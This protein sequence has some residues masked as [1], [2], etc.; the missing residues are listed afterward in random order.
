[1][2]IPT[3]R[4]NREE[5]LTIIKQL[6]EFD[7]LDQELIGENYRRSPLVKSTEEEPNPDVFYP[8]KSVD[9]RYLE[10]RFK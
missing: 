1:M 6:G 2:I 7:I 5:F 8:L 9:F 10:I 4:E 3:T